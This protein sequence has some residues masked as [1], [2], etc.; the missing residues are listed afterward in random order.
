MIHVAVVLAKNIKSAMENNPRN[1][2]QRVWGIE[3]RNERVETDKQWETSK[4]RK[5]LLVCFTYIAIGAYLWAIGVEKWWIHAIVPALGFM[6]STLAM[7]FFKR[8]WLAF[9]RGRE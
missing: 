2:E 1:L 7:P 3:E 8:K 6:I 5:V 4:T 9:F